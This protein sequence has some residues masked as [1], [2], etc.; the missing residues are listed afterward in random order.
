[1]R[2]VGYFVLGEKSLAETGVR[3]TNREF[4]ESRQRKYKIAEGDRG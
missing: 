4:D 3:L 1:M 2:P